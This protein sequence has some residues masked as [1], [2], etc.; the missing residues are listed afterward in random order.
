LFA[1]FICGEQIA[2]AEV[3]HHSDIRQLKEITWQFKI[4]VGGTSPRL[5]FHQQKYKS[6][7]ITQ[8]SNLLS[9]HTPSAGL[10]SVLL[11]RTAGS[12]HENAFY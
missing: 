5:E 2:M 12:R 4:K 9:W 10:R 1:I 11:Y 3:R 7:F 8:I 6:N